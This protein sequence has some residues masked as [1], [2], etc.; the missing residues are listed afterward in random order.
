MKR[1]ERLHRCGAEEAKRREYRERFIVPKEKGER[2]FN[3][4]FFDR[5]VLRLMNPQYQ[6]QKFVKTKIP[7]MQNH[8]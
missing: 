6:P 2:D 8:V 3:M 7:Q 1:Y 4:D 5:L